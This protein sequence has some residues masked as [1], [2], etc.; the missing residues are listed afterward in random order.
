M[1]TSPTEIRGPSYR[2]VLDHGVGSVEVMVPGATS[3]ALVTPITPP[4]ASLMGLGEPAHLVT[5]MKVQGVVMGGP[6]GTFQAY[7]PSM[8]VVGAQ[9]D[10]VWV[11]TRLDQHH[12]KPETVNAMARG[13]THLLGLM[14]P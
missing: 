14:Q 5:W 8:I 10:P 1:S 9:V 11:S 13:I 6:L 12:V 2:L 3:L 7:R 4:V